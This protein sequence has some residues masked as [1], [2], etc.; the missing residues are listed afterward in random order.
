[1]AAKGML[2]FTAL[3]ALV[4]DSIPFLQHV[5]HIQ[6]S[7][8][9]HSSARGCQSQALLITVAFRRPAQRPP[10]SG[11]SPVLLLQAFARH[12]RCVPKSGGFC[13]QRGFGRG[14]LQQSAAGD[15]ASVW[16][17]GH[18]NTL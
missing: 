9:M 4:P 18:V 13:L 11:S 5:S 10:P 15:V 1:M 3:L 2:F 17:D 8:T 16:A 6:G 12:P 7:N 14:Q